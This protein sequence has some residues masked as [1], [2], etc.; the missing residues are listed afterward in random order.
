[1]RKEKLENWFI[2]F[3][4]CNSLLMDKAMLFTQKCTKLRRFFL[5]SIWLMLCLII[6][7]ECTMYCCFRPLDPFRRAWYVPS[8]ILL[9]DKQTLDMGQLLGR[10]CV[11]LS[12]SDIK[13]IDQPNSDDM[14]S[15]SSNINSI[16]QF[17]P[18]HCYSRYCLELNTF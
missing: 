13:R 2:F 15:L 12:N 5:T 10:K 1:M 4:K 14:H 3:V 8:S 17:W 6:E 18:S 7:S 16:S 11:T 9:Y